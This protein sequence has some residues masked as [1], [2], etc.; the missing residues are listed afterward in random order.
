MEHEPWPEKRE[1]QL[2]EH[3]IT[4]AEIQKTPQK[5]QINKKTPNKWEKKTQTK[6]NKK[7]K[8]RKKPKTKKQKKNH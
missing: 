4:L 8:Q 3:H 2:K 1:A 6:Q 7:K 5:T